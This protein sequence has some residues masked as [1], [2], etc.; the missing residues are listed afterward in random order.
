MLTCSIDIK[1]KDIVDLW[2]YYC[3]TYTADVMLKFPTPQLCR[4]KG[5]IRYETYYKMLDLYHQFSVRMG[6]IMDQAR[7]KKE[8]EQTEDTI[9]R[10]LSKD[11]AEYIRKCKYCGKTLPVG[12]GYRICELCYKNSWGITNKFSL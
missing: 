3:K 11:K 8:R 1:N 10:F 2:L 5:L 9:M 7:L 4:D 6:K 12:Y